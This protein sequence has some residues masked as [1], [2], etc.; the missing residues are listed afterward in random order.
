MKIGNIVVLNNKHGPETEERKPIGDCVECEKPLYK[1][2]K[3]VYINDEYICKECSVKAAFE[4]STKDEFKEYIG[5]LDKK[6]DFA[7]WFYEQHFKIL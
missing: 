5:E 4:D 7:N 3:V 6:Q 1:G 2:D